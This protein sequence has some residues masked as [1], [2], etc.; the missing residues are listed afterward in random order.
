[1]GVT[2]AQKNANVVQSKCGDVASHIDLSAQG[3]RLQRKANLV[4][5]AAQRA[6]DPRPNNTG[7]PDELKSGIESLSG[8]SMDDVRVHYNS[9]KPA[10]VQ[11]LAYTQGADIHVAP[12][13][14]KHLPHEAWHVAQQMAGRVSPTTNIN[15]MSV[16]D[17]AGLEHEADVMGEKAVQ[18]KRNGHGTGFLKNVAVKTGNVQRMPTR[19]LIGR[20]GDEKELEGVKYKIE[21]CSS[22]IFQNPTFWFQEYLGQDETVRITIHNIFENEI[23]SYQAMALLAR[24]LA[25]TSKEFMDGADSFYADIIAPHKTTNGNTTFL[26]LRFKITNAG[27]FGADDGPGYVVGVRKERFR[28]TEP[29]TPKSVPL[30][31]RESTIGYTNG[32]KTFSSHHDDSSSRLKSFLSTPEGLDVV[33]TMDSEE[34]EK[35]RPFLGTKTDDQKKTKKKPS[36]SQ[37]SKKKGGIDKSSLLADAESALTPILDKTSKAKYQPQDQE[38]Q[39]FTSS[40][41]PDA[42]AKLVAEGARFEFV[43]KNMGQVS[44]GTV[45]YT[46]FSDPA[47]QTS[48]VPQTIIK[49][50]NFSDLWKSWSRVFDSLYGVTE[51]DCAKKLA[52]I[53]SFGERYDTVPAKGIRL[54]KCELNT[55]PQELSN[56][57][58]LTSRRRSHDMAIFNPQATGDKIDVFATYLKARLSEECINRLIQLLQTPSVFPQSRSNGMK[59]LSEC[60]NSPNAPFSTCF[61]MP[62]KRRKR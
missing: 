46:E 13:Q 27:I 35:V 44:D 18:C 41:I 10:T 54:E 56:G 51:Q 34:L 17:N 15:G 55:S 61:D 2:Y 50:V 19:E 36:K 53:P 22:D 7:M 4:N 1:M 6:S 33:G 52:K 57:K 47:T 49:G 39:T 25:V 24:N 31:V 3:E 38:L 43:R 62:K 29:V 42:Y 58:K 45:F 9:S 30:T 26:L 60:E 5:A 11:A 37:Q 14:E 32:D 20:D 12:G 16:N 59:R 23:E 28:G 40:V 48:D 21:Y 8:F